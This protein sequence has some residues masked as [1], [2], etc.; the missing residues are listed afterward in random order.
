M[1]QFNNPTEYFDLVVM[2][3][4]KDD[5]E[6]LLDQ[7]GCP[8][9]VLFVTVMNAI[10]VLGGVLFGFKGLKKD[11]TEKDNST[12]RSNSFMASSHMGL[13]PEEAEFLYNYARCGLAHEGITKSTGTGSATQLVGFEIMPKSGGYSDIFYKGPDCICVDARALARKALD[14]IK[15]IDQN[16]SLLKDFPRDPEA[17]VFSDAHAVIVGPDLAEF[18]RRR[19][20][21]VSA[22]GDAAQT[23]S[24]LFT[25]SMTAS[26][27]PAPSAVAAS[28]M[29]PPAPSGIKGT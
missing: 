10:D 11:G 24:G 8:A 14:A 16:R 28:V 6:Y 7:P 22:G 1:S 19:K 20:P 4:Y 29:P 23:T 27:V 17:K 12:A 2:K 25:A 18:E 9:G 5:I 13:K 15:A 26:H 3:Y 21:P